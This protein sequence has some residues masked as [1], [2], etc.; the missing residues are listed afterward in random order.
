MP[1]PA[2][3]LGGVAAVVLAGLLATSSAAA[4]PLRAGAPAPL[5]TWQPSRPLTTSS[6]MVAHIGEPDTRFS[7]PTDQR[8][9]ERFLNPAVER[10]PEW[11][12]F[13]RGRFGPGSYEPHI[14]LSWSATSC[15]PVRASSHEYE[16]RLDAPELRSVPLDPPELSD[17][18]LVPTWA[19]KW[20]PAPELATAFAPKRACPPWKTPRAVTIARYGAEHDTFTLLECDGSVAAD[21]LDRL[22]VLARPPRAPRP[23]LPLPLEPELN[24][25]GEWLPQVKVLHPRLIWVVEQIAR[26]FPNRLIYIVSGYRR[27][28]H[29][30]FHFKGRALDLSVLGIPKQKLFEKCHEL[31]DVGCGY[32][33]HHDFVHVDVRPFGTGHPVWIDVSK[34]GERSRYV[35]SWPGVVASGALEWAGEG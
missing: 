21:A 22:S 33:P 2:R 5:S 12:R 35:D 15:E 30:S 6:W 28:A 20:A 23:E 34:P 16:V 10:T 17:A 13:W 26:A 8:L 24:V 29:T 1:G 9:L 11:T 4:L 18:E 3:P 27:D 32:Y 19:L 31:R 14:P 7:L 25:H